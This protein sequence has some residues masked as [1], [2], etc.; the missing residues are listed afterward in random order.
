MAINTARRN[1]IAMLGGAS[2]AWPLLARAQQG[3]KPVI[4]YFNSR[5]PGDEPELLDSFR[6]GLSESGYV[7]GRN[8]AIQ[9]WWAE[10]QYDRLPVLA[11]DLVLHQVGVI[12]ANF[13]P[14]VAAKAATATIPIVF[15]SSS[16][17]VN[18]GIVASLDRPGANVTGVSLLATA[19]EAKRLELLRQVIPGAKLIGVLVNPKNPDDDLQ[20]RELQDA[21]GTMER[22]IYVVRAG[23]VPE[24]DT[25]FTTLTERKAG[26]LVVTSDP[27]FTSR[28]QQLVA[29][30]I[31]YKL[32]A[33]YNQRIFSDNG[34]LMSYGSNLA[35]GYRQ[36]GVYVGKIL[37]GAKPDELPVV[38]PTKFELVINLIT[39]KALGSEI[40]A[41]LLA[42][43]DQVIE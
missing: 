20:V 22:E 41:K 26:G 39:A 40:P 4:G 3:R 36:A 21:A 7:E 13:P 43:A 32:P 30:T 18:A 12:F 25:A 42:L 35:D 31:R 37:D 10:G 8:V 9:F 27:F 34:G 6:Q 15:T 17:P 11:A 29:L 1:F 14:V 19:L 23:T 28:R 16:D 24:I 5:S 2:L 38:Q 33:I